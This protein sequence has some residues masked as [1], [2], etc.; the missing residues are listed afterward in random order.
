MPAK[1][2]KFIRAIA[3]ISAFIILF[4]WM[5]LTYQII[6]SVFFTLLVEMGIYKWECIK[7]RKMLSI[8]A[9]NKVNNN[10]IQLFRR[11]RKW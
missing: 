8:D 10:N 2:Q 6:L 9:I 5:P 4:S 3:E 7:I 1:K 11:E